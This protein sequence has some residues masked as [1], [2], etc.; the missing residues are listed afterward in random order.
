MGLFSSLFGGQKPHD[1]AF[2]RNYEDLLEGMSRRAQL[3]KDGGSGRIIPVHMWPRPEADTS[4]SA[5]TIARGTAQ[6]S[7]LDL[8]LR[9]VNLENLLQVAG[10]FAY[11]TDA[12]QA[13]WIDYEEAK[14]AQNDRSHLRI[15]MDF[16]IY[17]RS[18]PEDTVLISAWIE[19]ATFT[20][21]TTWINGHA[22]DEA[23]LCRSTNMMTW[24][25]L[26]LR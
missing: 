3:R 4:P 21:G 23:D 17:D 14:V 2:E 13:V 15:K 25:L 16:P 24:R 22:D 7:L 9:C 8:Y 11:I 10:G 19:S 6:G 12:P 5:V 18:V 20:D 26:G 1:E